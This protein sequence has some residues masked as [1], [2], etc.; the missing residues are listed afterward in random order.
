MIGGFGQKTLNE[1]KREK[2]KVAK[3]W[4]TKADRQTDKQIERLVVGT[5]E[6]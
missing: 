3:K 5:L 2:E 4:G 1:K 6:N